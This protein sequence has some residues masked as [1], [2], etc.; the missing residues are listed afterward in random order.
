MDLEGVIVTK[1][2]RS[3]PGNLDR[4]Y[5]GEALIRQQSVAAI[6]AD[7]ALLDHVELIEAVMDHLDF[8]GKRDAIDL[9][10]ET[11]QLLGARVFNDLSAGFG[12]LT[13]GYYQLAAATLRDVMEILY[14]WAWFDRDM[15]KVT[16]W[17]KS[18]DKKRREIF[19][20]VK[21]R[22]FLD[23][24]DGF[25]DGKRGQ[26]YKML[27]EYAAHATWQGFALMRPSGGGQVIMGPFFDAGLMKAVLEEMAQLA[28]Q[29]GNYYSGFFPKDG[30]LQALDTSLRRLDVTGRWAETYLGRPHDRQFIVDM[31]SALAE[32]KS[33]G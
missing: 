32:L 30:D 3:A 15:A 9:D 27:C 8:F 6:E 11:V 29:I 25:K 16:E 14:L 18:D 4:L 19:S 2:K 13:R 22:T 24:F 12:Q 17:R 23:N 20:P 10:Q 26:A 7:E 33:E 1:Q 31:A 28:A 5:D 21:V